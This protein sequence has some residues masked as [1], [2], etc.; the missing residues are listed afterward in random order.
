[1]PLGITRLNTPLTPMKIWQAIRDAKAG[2]GVTLFVIPG[3]ALLGAGPESILPIVVMDSLMC[4]CT[5]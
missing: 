3:C 2:E 1:M 4:N 5:S